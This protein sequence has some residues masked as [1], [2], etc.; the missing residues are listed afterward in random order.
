MLTCLSFIESTDSDSIG[1]VTV[2]C[3]K[4]SVAWPLAF[5]S[6]FLLQLA[7]KGRDLPKSSFKPFATTLSLN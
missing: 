2:T 7:A 3:R 4:A 5:C 1:R 6:A